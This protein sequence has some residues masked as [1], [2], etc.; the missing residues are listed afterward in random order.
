MRPRIVIVT[1]S[2]Q[3]LWS[4]FQGQIRF[5]ALE[6][7]DIQTISSPGRELDE[8]RR[9]TG[10]KMHEVAMQRRIS[11]FAD[12]VAL[13]KLTR[14]LRQLRP[15]IV[16]T[17][18][19]K[20]GLLGTIAAMLAG[21]P[22]RIYT[23]NGLRFSTSV[24]FQRILL[25]AADKLGCLFA[26]EIL[27]VS[28]TLRQQAIALGICPAHR[29]RTLGFGGSHG[30]DL[31]K[32][33]PDQRNSVDRALVRLQYGLPQDALVLGYIGRVVWDK[34][35]AT[36][37]AAWR[38]LRDEFPNLRLLLCGQIEAGDPL[39]PELLEE[40]R[41]NL[42]V[43]LTGENRDDMPAVY[44]A[45][46]ICILASYREGLPN[47]VL[48]S[49][50][51]RLPVIATRIPGT[52]DAVQEGVTGLLVE[53]GDQ[54]TLARA[55]NLLIE[56]PEL[57]QR[58]GAAGRA[59]VGQRFDEQMISGLLAA[60][61]RRLLSHAF[62]AE[63]SDSELAQRGSPL[64]KA[65]KR[66]LDIVAASLGLVAVSPLLPLIAMM[67]RRNTRSTALFRQVRTG[68]R[69]KSFVLFKFRTMTEARGKDGSLLPDDKRLTAFGRF[70]RAT[71][72]D[73]LPQLVN[74]L[75]GEMSLVGPRPLLPEYLPRYNTHQRRRHELKPGITGW[76]QVKGR[77][78]LNWEQKLELDVWY[79]DH[80]SFLLD[81]RI[82]WQTLLRVIRRDGISWD[83]HATMPEFMGNARTTDG[84]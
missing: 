15:D 48:E 84:Q 45:I 64:D 67:V 17:H 51:M 37:A 41:G 49:Q 43:H 13:W 19:P 53:P 33:D 27:C 55:L 16:H 8:C 4:F 9:S 57:R 32:F 71:S 5:M 83:G 20:A 26:T 28:E 68:L 18:T 42:R 63:S 78:A 11:P 31:S 30:V 74:V 60:E 82:L 14:K 7:F 79:V 65:L 35:I 36:L 77:N 3:T 40:L 25:A 75:K 50:A 70:L 72:L 59:F 44:A 23:I 2:A 54:W 56:D 34:G 24:G 6:G 66:T 39:P 21:V 38:M 62:P 10:V 73:E 47:S 29:V 12:A 76:A 46:D 81:I 61:Y 1:T 22:I 58:L 52:V 80:R 69:G